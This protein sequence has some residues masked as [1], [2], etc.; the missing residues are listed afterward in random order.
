MQCLVGILKGLLLSDA[1]SVR[2]D[3]GKKDGGV[4]EEIGKGELWLD[5]MYERCIKKICIQIFQANNLQVHFRRHLCLTGEALQM[6]ALISTSYK[7]MLAKDYI[8]LKQTLR[9]GTPGKVPDAKERNHVFG[10]DCS[11]FQPSQMLMTSTVG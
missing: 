2:V 3:L 11:L 8:L 10:T 5:I 1:G 9:R 4:G 7:R 6:D